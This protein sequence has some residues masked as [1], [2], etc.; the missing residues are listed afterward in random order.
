MKILGFV[1]RLSDVLKVNGLLNEESS[2]YNLCYGSAGACHLL[3]QQ[4]LRWR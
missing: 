2:A 3:N 1:L 4:K